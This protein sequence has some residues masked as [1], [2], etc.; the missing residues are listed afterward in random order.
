MHPFQQLPLTTQPIFYDFY[1]ANS[2]ACKHNEYPIKR[3]NLKR[4]FH[5]IVARDLFDKKGFN[6]IFLKNDNMILKVQE[7]EKNE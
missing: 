5:A 1:Y 4:Y 7:L 2:K 3:E 6:M